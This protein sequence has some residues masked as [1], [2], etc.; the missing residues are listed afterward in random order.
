MVVIG[1]YS[2]YNDFLLAESRKI[3]SPPT[4]RHEFQRPPDAL[5]NLGRNP[6]PG[7]EHVPDWRCTLSGPANMLLRLERVPRLSLSSCFQVQSVCTRASFSLVVTATLLLCCRPPSFPSFARLRSR[8]R[9]WLCIVGLHNCR[10]I[11]VSL[12]LVQY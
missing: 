11:Q 7:I 4:M 8:F 9:I 10:W 1:L 3:I 5:R 12:D 6:G 2:N